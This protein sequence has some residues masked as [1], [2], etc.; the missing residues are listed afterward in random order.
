MAEKSLVL[1]HSPILLYAL[2]IFLLLDS[3]FI[4]PKAFLLKGT[5]QR[6]YVDP[7]ENNTM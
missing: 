1:L 2:E 3:S 6:L 4:T 7:A 5:I